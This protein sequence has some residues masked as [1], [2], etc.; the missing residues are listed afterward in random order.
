MNG[1]LSQAPDGQQRRHP[2]VQ[3][4]APPKDEE[5]DEE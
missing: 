3:D 2:R 4:G 1:T 5:E